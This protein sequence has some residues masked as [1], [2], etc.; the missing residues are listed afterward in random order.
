MKLGV[1][2]AVVVDVDS[3]VDVVVVDLIGM[4]STMKMLLAT[5]ESLAGTVPLKMEMLRSPQKGVAMVHHVVLTVVVV[6]V[7]SVMEKWGMGSVLGGCLNVVVELDV[8]EYTFC[9]VDYLSSVKM[10]CM[11]SYYF[12]PLFII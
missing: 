6:E 1:E 2:G 12:Y 8:G 9:L 11:I 5:M 4:Q 10:E 7:V 3:G